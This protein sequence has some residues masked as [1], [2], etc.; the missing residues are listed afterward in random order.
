[1]MVFILSTS[2]TTTAGTKIT[3]ATTG[4][5]QPNGTS[6]V[7]GIAAD[8]ADGEY[9]EVTFPLK[10]SHQFAREMVPT[11]LGIGEIAVN[12]RV[13]H[14]SEIMP[15]LPG[16]I[17]CGWRT[18]PGTLF[19]ITPR[20]GE[21]SDVKV[22]YIAF[23]E[24]GD[25]LPRATHWQDGDNYTYGTTAAKTRL[26]LFDPGCKSLGYLGAHAAG[27]TAFAYRLTPAGQ[28]YTIPGNHGATNAAEEAVGA[29]LV[30]QS[31]QGSDGL[32]FGDQTGLYTGT[33]VG[34]IAIG[35]FY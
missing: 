4:F 27:Q 18:R 31:I 7:I 28:D 16:F 25:S 29:W 10:G 2:Q 11:T 34:E 15:N 6:G 19:D 9:L 35:L 8:G 3:S 26:C 32:Y 33:A 1:M 24:S 12:T 21:S 5:V 13:N 22:V 20:G 30:N 14:P 23:A 17:P